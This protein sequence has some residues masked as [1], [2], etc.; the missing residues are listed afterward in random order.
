VLTVASEDEVDESSGDDDFLLRSDS[1]EEF[2]N[3][4]VGPC[5]GPR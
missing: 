3:L 5:E 2:L 1:G 4:R